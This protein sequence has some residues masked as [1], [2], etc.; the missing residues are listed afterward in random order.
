MINKKD[1]TVCVTEAKSLRSSV[2]FSQQNS[3]LNKIAVKVKRQIC[4]LLFD[5]KKLSE[6]H[7]HV[8]LHQSLNSN[9]HII[10]NLLLTLKSAV[11]S[12]TYV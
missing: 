12:D 3:N 4:R 11:V 8:K 1:Y 7:Y 9:V 6:I 10:G 2:S 5:F